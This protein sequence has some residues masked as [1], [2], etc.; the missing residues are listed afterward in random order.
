MTPR[1]ALIEIQR[2]MVRD[3]KRE[4]GD[5]LYGDST[6]LR[7]YSEVYRRQFAGPLEIAARDDLIERAAASDVVFHGDFH[8][9]KLAQLSPIKI[10][11]A[12]RE[13]GRTVRLALEMFC[14]SDQ[15][16]LD[17]FQRMEIDEDEFLRAVRYEERWGFPWENYRNLVYFALGEGIPIAGI[18]CRDRPEATL[19]DRDA[20]AARRIAGILDEHPD[21]LVYVF[22]GELHLA[23]EHLPRALEL[24]CGR[25]PRRTIVHQNNETVYWRLAEFGLEQDAALV[26]IADDR[27]CL[28]HCTPLVVF[29][30]FRNWVER[31][32][33]LALEDGA[34]WEG[35]GQCIDLADQVH[36]LVRVIAEFLGIRGVDLDDFTVYTPH[37][38]DFL[39]ILQ[40][41]HRLDPAR[42]RWIRNEIEHA[43][44][45]YIPE[46]R[47]VYLVNLSINRAAEE[48]ARFLHFQSAGYGGEPLHPR[49]AFYCRVLVE[50]LG[51]FGSKV[52]NHKR[53]AKGEEYYRRIERELLDRPLG[54]SEAEFLRVARHVLRHRDLERRKLGPTPTSAWPRRL[55]LLDPDLHRGVTG[56]LGHLLGEEL[57]G[58]LLAERITKEEIRSLFE[59]RFEEG[60]TAERIY[61]ELRRRLSRPFLTLEEIDGPRHRAR[62]PFLSRKDRGRA[63]ARRV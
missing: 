58:A 41:R 57:Y 55:F 59:T 54:E 34:W 25:P 11:R 40:E 30:S 37:D 19:A 56:A 4:I 3:L 38:L 5:A 47:I 42:L 16:A 48:A 61:F 51:F 46:A 33:E 10:L 20:F 35:D 43:K 28:V 44:S 22:C 50:A 14:A 45:L 9:L 7:Q 2:R 26:R 17:R 29:Q 53:T 21:D 12:L 6:C 18:D 39:E 8:T 23:P 63:T 60:R 24:A 62:I 52:V 15:P 32:E 27:F 31:Q 36:Q 49:C 13:R 1:E